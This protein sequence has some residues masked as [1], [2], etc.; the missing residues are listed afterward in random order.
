[1]EVNQI[2][3]MQVRK[4]RKKIIPPLSIF[5]FS[6]TIH[7]SSLFSLDQFLPPKKFLQETDKEKM[8]FRIFH[9]ASDNQHQV[10]CQS[11]KE[12]TRKATRF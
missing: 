3:K 2:T 6:Q 10:K 11:R 5:K 12:I 9:P 1:M 4:E 8:K 7:L